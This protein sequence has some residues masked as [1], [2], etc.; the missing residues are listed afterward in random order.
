MD[1]K[2]ESLNYHSKG[3]PGKIEVNNT[4]PFITQTD[5]A[6]AYRDWRSKYD[7]YCGYRCTE[8]R[9]IEV[10]EARAKLQAKIDKHWKKCEI[11]RSRK[12]RARPEAL[13]GTCT[14]KKHA[15]WS[16][17]TKRKD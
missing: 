17:K 12:F 8:K 14:A 15:A 5:L 13:C 2:K 10:D 7:S 1:Y 4:K 6:L 16:K 11:L 9:R 3:R